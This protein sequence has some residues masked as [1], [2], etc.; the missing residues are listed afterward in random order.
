MT[1]STRSYKR[2]RRTPKQQQDH[3]TAAMNKLS[4][5]ELSE[6]Q[7][8]LRNNILHFIEEH[9]SNYG[10]DSGPAMFVIQGDAGTGKSVVLNSL[11]NEIQRLSKFN[12]GPEFEVLQGTQNFLIVNHPEM[13]KLYVRICKNF[14][15]IAR[16]SLE[17]PT[18]LINNLTKNKK[19]ADVVII[20]EAHLL[21][22]SK[23]G[24]K[25]F[26][27]DNHL[28][29]LMS[30]AKILIIVYDEKQAL[31]TG[32]YWDEDSS[33]GASLISYY[34][35]VPLDKKNWYTLKQQF[36][37][38]A[39]DDVLLWINEISTSGKIPKFPKSM[40]KAN[41]SN[42][43]FDFKLWEDCGEMYE[44]L[45][46]KNETHGQCRMLCTYDFPYRLDGKD[47]FVTCGDNFKLRWDRYAPREL[48]PWSER[49]D[50]IDEVGSVYTIQGFDLNYAGV[51][52]GRSIGYDPINDCIQL[53]PELYDDHAGFVRK[54]N[55]QDP[56]SVRSKIIMNSLNVL[57]T[58]GVKGLYVYAYDSKLRERLSKSRLE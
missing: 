12:T 25:R 20:D 50:T 47:Y 28:E 29:E 9:L 1:V 35:Q 16:S 7:A 33:N 10:V 11:F 18:S 43:S 45:K 55:I 49:A 46:L 4:H 56:H 30:L 42:K 53:K 22:S 17:R 48:M 32:C 3:E 26:M 40:L 39:P 21:A 41:K 19:M 51:I 34:D 31:R 8:K 52:L 37:V 23:D 58:R 38:A 5:V 13:L 36:R 27:G 6:E 2:P 15:H 14:N 24:F 44:E 57:L 54:K